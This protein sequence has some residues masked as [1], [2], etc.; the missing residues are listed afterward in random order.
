MTALYIVGAFGLVFG[1]AVLIAVLLAARSSRRGRYH[2]GRDE[3]DDN[4]TAKPA[5]P[6]RAPLAI[7]AAIYTP[8]ELARIPAD[9]ELPRFPKGGQR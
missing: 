9:V 4:Y 1:P 7:E 5:T 2:G 8:A 3:P 6:V